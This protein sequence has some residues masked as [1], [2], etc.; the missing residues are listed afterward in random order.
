MNKEEKESKLKERLAEM[1]V[2]ENDLRALGTVNIA[3]VD[4]VG[5]GP[6]AGPVCAAAVVLPECFDVLGVDDS[7]KISEKR[8]EVLYGEITSKA[9]AWGIGL[10]D[11]RR[12]DEINILN[13]TKEAMLAAITEANRMLKAAAGDTA[14]ITRTD[15]DTETAADTHTHTDADADTAAH[16]HAIDHLLIDA[17]ALPAAGIPYTAIV[18]GDSRSVSIAAASIVA[19]VT[20]DRMMITFDKVYPGYGFVSNKG[21]G[22][23]AHYEGIRKLGLTPI[24]RRT[25]TD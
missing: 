24:H 6:L 2:F 19:K 21:Y 1:S 10:V 16:T 13:A 3:G 4:E 22:T 5:R 9:L 17:V 12:I 23:K 8:R 18:K 25:F 14:A 15:A 11:N 7:K 20:R